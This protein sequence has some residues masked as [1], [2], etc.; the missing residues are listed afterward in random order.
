[1]SVR[2]CMLGCNENRPR[3]GPQHRRHGH[4]GSQARR[5]ARFPDFPSQ[6][7]RDIAVLDRNTDLDVSKAY[8]RAKAFYFD[9]VSDPARERPFLDRL[10]RA[11]HAAR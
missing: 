4:S 3:S 1:M 9:H 7:D 2:V 5:G 8:R 6:L 10:E 11:P